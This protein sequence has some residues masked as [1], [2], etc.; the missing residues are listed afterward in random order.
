VEERYNVKSISMTIVISD[1]EQQFIFGHSRHD[2]LCLAVVMV[3]N[4]FAYASA[5]ADEENGSN[6][7]ETADGSA[8]DENLGPVDIDHG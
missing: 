1:G 3:S 6:H 2:A 7:D 4:V 8:A 5:G